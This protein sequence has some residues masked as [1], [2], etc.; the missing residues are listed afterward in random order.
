MSQLKGVILDADSLHPADLDLSSILNIA[1]ISWQVYSAS[2]PE[3][4]LE[5]ISQADIVLTNKALVRAPEIDAAA[6]LQYIGILATGTNAVDLDAAQRRNI[7]TTNIT[8]YGTASV[9]Q[10][11]FALILALTTQLSNYAQ[12]SLDGRWSDSE[13]FC[14]LD[15]PVREL[16]GLT[17]G[18]IG[19]GILGRA[20]AAI[21]KA[22][23]MNIIVADLPGR[24]SPASDISRVPLE[25]FLQQADIVSLHCPLADNTHH[26]IGSRE[27]ELMK[28]DALLI[29]CARGSI[30]DEQALANALTN[31]DIAGA[32]LDVLS[33]EPPPPDH[34]LLSGAIPNLIITPH[35]AW[36]AKD[37][38]QRLVDQAGRHLKNW[39]DTSHPD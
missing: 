37:A 6:H 1:N 12:A 32:A 9:A 27:L 21:A 38:R 7:T 30:V 18:I 10:H 25:Q 5:R 13:Y 20:V 35:C 19:Y 31:G 14:L 22:F 11:T 15:Y 39:L 29:N 8:D 24:P 26:L 23:G 2:M 17:L 3:T 4:V 16:S 34:I 28:T 36:G 33:Q